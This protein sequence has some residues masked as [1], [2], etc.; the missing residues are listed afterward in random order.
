MRRFNLVPS[1][2]PRMFDI[3]LPFSE[4]R[5]HLSRDSREQRRRAAT[6][7]LWR[8]LE[9]YRQENLIVDRA[10]VL[11]LRLSLLQ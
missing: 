6:A 10:G 4:E 7:D 5:R 2:S 9:K 3:E 11:S 8:H 1:I